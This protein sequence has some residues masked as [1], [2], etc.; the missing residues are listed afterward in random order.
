VKKKWRK[1][2]DLLVKITVRAIN[3]PNKLR[4]R[5]YLKSEQL[6]N[7]TISSVASLAMSDPAQTS[8]K[9]VPLKY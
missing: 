6:T 9:I 1:I 8:R 4:L 5:Y 7:K 2:A 3:L